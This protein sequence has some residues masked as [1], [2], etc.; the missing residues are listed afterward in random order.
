MGFVADFSAENFKPK[1]A[2]AQCN[3]SSAASPRGYLADFGRKTPAE[4]QETFQAKG[5]RQSPESKMRR[6]ALK[7]GKSASF[8]SG[9]GSF[10]KTHSKEDSANREKQQKVKNLRTQLKTLKQQMGTVAKASNVANMTEEKLRDEIGRAKDKLASRSDQVKEK[11]K[12]KE[13]A[14]KKL[15][16]TKKLV[17]ILEARIFGPAS[18]GHDWK[19]GLGA[20][21]MND[22]FDIKLG[23]RLDEELNES[24]QYQLF[25]FFHRQ[26]DQVWS[27][28]DRASDKKEE[29]AKLHA[30]V[31]VL[32]QGIAALTKQ[33][34]KT[35][36]T[37]QALSRKKESLQDKKERL[38]DQLYQLT[39]SF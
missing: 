7:S 1:P 19:F 8:C 26:Q 39:S 18:R 5:E 11:T 4:P 22:C 16:R 25:N 33:H 10:A 9:F 29:V 30:E 38:Q 21:L 6:A 37:A 35:V 17:N 27:L 23:F 28:Q 14:D 24:Q 36:S 13:D 32:E 12:E 34:T 15:E 31:R 3:R 2:S 20:S